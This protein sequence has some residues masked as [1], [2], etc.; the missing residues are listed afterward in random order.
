MGIE[1]ID[2]TK[3]KLE[4]IPCLMADG[5]TRKLDVVASWDVSHKN[6]VLKLGDPG[7]VVMAKT[8]HGSIGWQFMSGAILLTTDDAG[9]LVDRAQSVNDFIDVELAFLKRTEEYPMSADEALEFLRTHPGEHRFE[10]MR[11]SGLHGGMGLQRWNH[12]S[13]CVEVCTGFDWHMDYSFGEFRYRFLE[14]RD[15]PNRV[16]VQGELPEVIEETERFEISRVDAV[17]SDTQVYYED[18]DGISKLL[19]HTITLSELKA[20]KCHKRFTRD[21]VALYA[22]PPMIDSA[23][24]GS[25]YYMENDNGKWLKLSPSLSLL[26]LRRVLSSEGICFGEYAPGQN[27]PDRSRA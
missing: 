6:V 2:F 15:V 25:L 26:S 11:H 18:S 10:W 27:N 24:K 8:G 14:T 16:T 21:I 3:C 17:L 12:F 4:P 5:R 19:P 13:N 20:L 23:L 22:T 9:L 1:T 7:S